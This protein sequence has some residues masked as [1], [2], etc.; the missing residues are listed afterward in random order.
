MKSGSALFASMAV[1]AV[2]VAAAIVLTFAPPAHAT[3]SRAA[4]PGADAVDGLC[5]PAPG[6]C[7][8]VGAEDSNPPHP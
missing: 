2:A 7:L 6:R 3:A 1:I 8:P 5:S 4:N